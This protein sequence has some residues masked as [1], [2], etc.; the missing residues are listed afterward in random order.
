VIVTTAGP[1]DEAPV[2]WLPAPE[3]AW[4]LPVV[5]IEPNAGFTDVAEPVEQALRADFGLQAVVLCPL[6]V[7]RDAVGGYTRRVMVVEAV[8]ASLPQ[9]WRP[10]TVDAVTAAPFAVA[11]HRDLLHRWLSESAPD[12]VPPDRA[13]WARPGWAAGVGA[14]IARQLDDLGLA[15]SGPIATVKNWSLS[16]VL[17][18][19]TSSGDY[20]FKAVP[21][22]F[23]REP[24]LTDALARRHPGRVPE[25]V[26]L[27]P[28]DG[29]MLMRAF[30]GSPL[31]QTEDWDEWEAALRGYAEIQ[32]AWLN[33][34]ALLRRLGCSDR[35]PRRLAEQIDDLLADAQSGRGAVGLGHPRGLN[36]QELH[37]LRALAP[38]LKAA[39]AEWAAGGVP[40]TLEHGDIHAEN[41]AVRDGQ[42]TYFD[43]TDGCIAHPFVC[44]TT[45]GENAK[46]ALR[47]R[48]TRAYLECWRDLA[49]RAE[50]DM[51]VRLARPLGA[52]HL[53]VSYYDIHHATEPMQRWQLAGA[54]AFFLR[55]TLK[56]QNRL[57]PI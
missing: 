33:D 57:D 15:P 32:I 16:C 13:A 28:E 52:L 10:L 35:G 56:D 27:N 24:A 34:L 41:I 37:E 11:E 12:A 30:A 19:P 9:S 6:C 40:E 29:W 54:T 43:W 1:A 39:C 5:E 22:L 18:V 51:A 26:A 49:S 36:E 8:P 44:L 3:S 25:V 48:L 23:A 14:W 17:R 7:E 42:F 46:P 45:L 31:R 38:R 20:Y 53:A 4:R 55:Q 50:L 2:A 21:P 47:D